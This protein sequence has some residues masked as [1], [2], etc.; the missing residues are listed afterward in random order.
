MDP[1]KGSTAVSLDI[2]CVCA[3]PEWTTEGER[4]EGGPIWPSWRPHSRGRRG[5][6][7]GRATA[8]SAGAAFGTLALRALN[9]PRHPRPQV[10]SQDEVSS[11][12]SSPICYT[13]MEVCCASP[14]SH[15]HACP[16][17]HSFICVLCVHSAGNTVRGR[18]IHRMVAGGSATSSC[19]GMGMACGHAVVG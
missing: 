19:M 16:A 17:R 5:S 14:A 12:R 9:V 10:G 13:P 6:R 1:L 3:S 11:T 7:G 2:R 8:A 18:R 4:V 15:I